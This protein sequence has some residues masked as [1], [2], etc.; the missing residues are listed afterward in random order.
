MKVNTYLRALSPKSLVLEEFFAI[1]WLVKHAI[2]RS[3]A[4][5]SRPSKAGLW[6]SRVGSSPDSA[7]EAVAT[8]LLRES[9]QETGERKPPSTPGGE[10]PIRVY[11][12]ARCCILCTAN[13]APLTDLTA[14]TFPKSE[15]SPR[16]DHSAPAG[17]A[18]AGG[19]KHTAHLAATAQIGVRSKNRRETLTVDCY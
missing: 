17:G 8:G 12:T 13:A 10:T 4:R 16:R 7:K 9:I 18:H 19:D 2:T 5:M 14:Y 15:G 1:P 6:R 3:S 11:E